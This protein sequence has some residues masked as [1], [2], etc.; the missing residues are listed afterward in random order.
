M[1]P[2]DF[3]PIA[4]HIWQSTLFAAVAVLLTL[5][6]RR[7][8]ARLRY[9]ILLAASFKF[10]LPFSWLVSLGREFQWRSAPAA[11]PHAVSTV[12]DAI[13][14]PTFL[15]PTVA[16]TPAP[17]HLALLPLAIWL[18]WGCGSLIVAAGWV[19]EWLRIRAVVRV[20]KPLPLALP[21]PAMSV[22]SPLEPGVFG[23]FRPLLLL[24]EGIAE[25]LSP[26]QLRV[27]LAH[28][29]CHVR[30]RDNLAAA[31]H[32]LVEALFWFHPL[33]WWLDR[34]IAEERERACD[35]EVLRMGGAPVAYAETILAVCKS[36]V[37]SPIA[38]MS[39]ISGSDLKKRVV[40]VMTNPRIEN[41]GP[42]RK[43]L[44]SALGIA[45]IVAPL[46]FGIVNAP[47]LYGQS[48]D[49]S[50]MQGGDK[51]LPSFEVASI[52]KHA[53]DGG[54]G[55]TRVFMGGVDV[56][57]F[58]VSNLTAKML[59]ATAYSVKDFQISGG[60]SWINSEHWDIDAKVDDSLAAQ[61]QKLPRQQ[62]RAQ[63]ALMLRS[64]LVDRFKLQITRSTKE[65]AVLALVVA[66][67]GS[68]LKEVPPPDPSAS[69]VPP[70]PPPANGPLP[71]PAPGMSMG[72]S[73]NGV[74][75]GI[76]NA[77]PIA[78]LVNRL[79]VLLG[80]PVID[81]TGLKGT[82]QYTLRF[83][84]SSLPAVNQPGGSGAESAESNPDAPSIFAA[85]QDQL[86]LKLELTKAPVE[87]ITID[88]IEEP[89]PN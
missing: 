36:Y 38:C 77:V 39:G 37:E 35:E 23:I 19:R 17:H 14:A 64:L 10:L 72:E 33:V 27:V 74:Q 75:I 2:A 5:A 16:A 88:H 30:R 32:M 43:L 66:K 60:P 55:P 47:L 52:K 58:H 82:Y 34:R 67:G 9:A 80:Q 1:I 25:K 48:A 20:A 76:A 7:N 29:L 78:D 22:L 71:M 41:L 68:K 61:L 89:S 84:E 79:S 18:V 56:S 44:L 4:S 40:N 85:V 13:S 31:L 3:A 59:I 51:L 86:G 12:T 50:N 24:P 45:T 6:L 21:I 11:L 49:A 54:V 63:T 15:M 70:A 46:V 83:S 87:T 53:D 62:Q 57:Q 8:H 42:A 69:I 65:G 26:A 28:E 81:R 73:I